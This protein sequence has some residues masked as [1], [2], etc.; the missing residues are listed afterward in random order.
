MT[1]SA[2]ISSVATAGGFS[3]PQPGASLLLS[4]SFRHQRPISS[5]SSP[6]LSTSA[7]PAF[8]IL[9]SSTLAA[10]RAFAALEADASVVVLGT[11][12]LENA[13]EEIRWR[14]EK[15]QIGWVDLDRIKTQKPTESS[16]IDSE[17]VSALEQYLSTF[18]P[19]NLPRFLCITDTLFSST[20]RRS[21]ASAAL[22][23]TL[24]RS[25]NINVNTTDYPDLCDFSFATT[26]RFPDSPLESSS[27]SDTGNGGALQIAI[28][29]N[30]QGCRLAGRI[31]REVVT[32]LPRDVGRAV[33][34]VGRM[35]V[36]AK[37][38][39]RN[40]AKDFGVGTVGNGGAPTSVAEEWEEGDPCA[41]TDTPSTP[42]LPVPQR[43]TR[44]LSSALD[45]LNG[46]DT[47]SMVERTR[48]RMK[49]IAQIS[50]YWPFDKLAGMT[51][52]EMKKYLEDE[53]YEGFST[54]T[55]TTLANLSKT[56]TNAFQSPFLP[57]T[58]IHSLHPSP[59]SL[60]KLGQILLIGSGPGHPSLLTLAAH[61]ALTELADI[62]LADKLVPAAVLALIPSRVE[63]VI[64]RKF[65]GNA[66]RAQQEMME[67]AVYEARRGRCV[68]RLKQGDP[69][70]Y[71]RFGEEVLYFRNP[72]S[73]PLSPLS[74]STSPT[75][76]TSSPPQIPLPPT[77]VIPGVSSALAAPTMFNVP[78]TQ[79]GAATSFLII[80]PVGKG[81][82]ALEM[83]K[84][85]R[86]RTVAI[87]MGVARLGSVVK[88]LLGSGSDSGAEN[89]PPYLPIA[90][91]ERASMPD[92][93]VIESTLED[94]ERAM[95][96]AEVGGQRPPGMMVV[97]WSVL[98]LWGKGNVDVLDE[99]GGD[100]DGEGGGRKRKKGGNS[101]NDGNGNGVLDHDS[102]VDDNGN[103]PPA[104][105]VKIVAGV[106]HEDGVAKD[107][108][109]VYQWL[110][111]GI[112][113]RVREGLSPAWDLFNL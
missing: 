85:E 77:L 113:W 5:E 103:N 41:D 73:L 84:Y 35:R 12:G 49:W 101:G 18:S 86:G 58:S 97:G 26:Y 110:G 111:D 23:Y 67:R 82:K 63:V 50:E 31:K 34:N 98:A 29:T 59:P 69:A 30:G 83:P 42:N 107:I 71:G 28:T 64:A 51:E 102:N 39:D 53:G 94:V 87:L 105:D 55:P 66:D 15:R 1:S 36:L 21:R 96:S 91:I 68:V 48:R 40:L 32:R 92:Q 33:G 45:G 104:E 11:G 46:E 20:T 81:G 74:P 112:C 109:R 78:C 52:E 76:L 99:D 22:I 37:E 4:F 25:R 38:R 108:H 75:S 27:S 56:A 60:T 88:A 13:C 19:S 43:P 89:Y 93:R 7:T 3:V 106:M 8:L 9:G 2:V 79:R 14:V 17:D 24:C 70:I 6:C 65:P 72:P 57:P 95:E 90:I 62:V 54:P 44:T 47:E 16:S 10:Q 100:E 61:R 80:S